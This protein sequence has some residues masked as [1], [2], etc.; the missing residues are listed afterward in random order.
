MSPSYMAS[1]TLKSVLSLCLAFSATITPVLS[2]PT[3][4]QPSNPWVPRSLKSLFEPRAP[5]CSGTGILL[6]NSGATKSFTFWTSADYTRTLLKSVTV[7]S[8]D[9]QFVP[10]DDGWTGTVQRGEYLPAT[11]VEVN[12]APTL[13]WGDISLQQGCD[14]GATLSSTTD[15]TSQGFT[16]NINEDP[17]VPADALFDPATQGTQCYPGDQCTTSATNVLD[18]TTGNY[19]AP[20]APN[21][22]SNNY[23]MGK[24]G[25][26]TEA[27]QKA[28]IGTADVN[29]TPQVTTSNNCFAV[30]FS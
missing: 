26:S 28:F 19:W 23:I 1:G 30:N 6:S 2:V 17:D 20:K 12:M 29:T 21:M 16:E 14:G 7:N 24:L 9:T 8:G 15:G 4:A 18:T 25:G 10:L 27:L 13:A 22:A 3:Q 11:W 5:T